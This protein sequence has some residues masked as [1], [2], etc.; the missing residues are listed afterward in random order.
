MNQWGLQESH[1]RMILNVLARFPE[2]REARIFG[3][4]AIGNFKPGSDVDIALF[5]NLQPDCAM[6]ISAVLNEELP[7]AF[8]FDV[9]DYSRIE[10]PNLKVHIDQYG[11]KLYRN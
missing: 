2:I 8:Q 7:L 5:G 11:E 3:S 10:N 6:Q 4:R 9:V 1:I